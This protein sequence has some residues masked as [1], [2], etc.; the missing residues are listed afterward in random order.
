MFARF[1]PATL[2]VIAGSIMGL[3]ATYLIKLG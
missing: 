3:G 2:V 1:F